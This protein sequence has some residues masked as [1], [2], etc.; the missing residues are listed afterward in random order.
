VEAEPSMAGHVKAAE[1]A[2]G[3]LKRRRDRLA[4]RADRLAAKLHAGGA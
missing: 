2:I 1:H 4:G 3:A